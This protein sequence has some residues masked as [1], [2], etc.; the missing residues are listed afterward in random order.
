MASREM[1]RK[2]VEDAK[3][4][5]TNST[6][7]SCPKT[8]KEKKHEERERNLD[9]RFQD[10]LQNAVYVKRYAFLALYLPFCMIFY[11]V[12]G[13]FIYFFSLWNFS[14]LLLMCFFY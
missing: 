2:K 7:C 13:V 4:Q 5:T 8:E 9:I 11:L 3:N 6:C 1:E 14:V 10:Y 12:F